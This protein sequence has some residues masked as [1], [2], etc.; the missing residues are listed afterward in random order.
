MARLSDINPNLAA[1]LDMVGFSEGTSTSKH[2]KNDGYDIVVDG[3]NS[4]KVFTSYS[5]HPNV[6]VTVNSKG[7]KSTAAG[8]YQLLNRWWAPYAELLKLKDFSPESQD[9]IAI[10]QIKERGALDDIKLGNITAA[11]KKCSNIWASFPGAGYGQFE[12]NIQKLLLAYTKAGGVLK[13]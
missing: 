3:I 8:R 9:K 2:T 10:Q 12:H 13:S 1:F 5:S 7:L 11:I 4:P 6:L